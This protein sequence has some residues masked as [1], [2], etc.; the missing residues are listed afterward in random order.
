MK[1]SKITIL[2]FLI[3][4][5]MGSFL[6][7]GG[8]LGKQ[9]QTTNQPGNS[10][11]IVVNPKTKNDRTLQLDTLVFV[12]PT[13][14]PTNPPSIIPTQPQT[15]TPV[16]TVQGQYCP[17][18]TVK[19]PNCECNPRDT[20]ALRCS[21][22]SC[23]PNPDSSVKSCIY[24]PVINNRGT[25]QPDPNYSSHLNDPNC[26]M[27]CLWK[28]VI[29]L[30]PTK[31]TVVKVSINTSGSITVSDP[32]YPKDGWKNITAFPNGT[33][34]Y[35]GKK[36]TELFYETDISKIN[37]P[38]NGIIIPKA[39]LE[40]KLEEIITKLGLIKNEREEFMSFWMQKLIK[41]DSPYILFSVIGSLEKDRIDKIQISP[42]PNTRI[43]FLAYF[44]PLYKL[45]SITPLLLP[46]FPPKRTGFTEVEWGGVID[47]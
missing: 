8:F 25:I 2:G 18:D 17:E 37:P 32:F 33:L 34:I 19:A 16:P 26:Q 40:V 46:D 9:D 20:K 41:L 15:L 4:V 13:P 12:T 39:D 23:P 1:F 31:Q 5:F 35:N 44:K 42:E 27:L 21:G 30:Y 3:V 14:R 28:P 38:K 29:Y 47:Y 22:S 45:I 24:N 11:L 6:M 43:E 10:S 7:S 36:Y